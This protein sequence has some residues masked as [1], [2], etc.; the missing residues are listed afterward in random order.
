MKLSVIPEAMFA[1][2]SCVEIAFEALYLLVEDSEVLL[3]SING[4]NVICI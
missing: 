3:E 2:E 4:D 1:G